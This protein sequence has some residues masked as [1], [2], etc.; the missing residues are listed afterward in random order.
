MKT[1]IRSIKIDQLDDL[2]D[3]MF[4]HY[5]GTPELNVIEFQV[6][7]TIEAGVRAV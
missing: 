3:N 7:T 5:R 2:F 4:E 1:T 6:A